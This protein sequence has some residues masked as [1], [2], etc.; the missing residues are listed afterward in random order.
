MT[1]INEMILKLEC[2]QYYT[3]LDLILGYYHT[4]LRNNASKLCTIIL[5][6]LKYFYIFLT[7]GIADYTDNFQQNMNDL[8]YEFLLFVCT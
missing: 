3:S 6:W 4:R 8:F 2:F 5:P 7:M 1:N